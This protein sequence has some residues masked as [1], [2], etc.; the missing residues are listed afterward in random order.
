ML[1]C[2]R[3][4]TRGAGLSAVRRGL[5]L[6]PAQAP[7]TTA[8]ARVAASHSTSVCRDAAGN[9]GAAVTRIPLPRGTLRPACSKGHTSP[10]TRDAGHTSRMV[11]PGTLGYSRGAAPCRTQPGFPRGD[12]QPLPPARCVTRRGRIGKV[13]HATHLQGARHTPRGGRPVVACLRPRRGPFLPSRSLALSRSLS[14][15]LVPSRPL[16]LSLARR[17]RVEA[18]AQ[19]GC[20]Q[21]AAS[22][23][24]VVGGW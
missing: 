9:K 5:A 14:L 18:P 2:P 6:A 20:R 10:F 11:D 17:I 19:R 23:L 24:G 3:N 4:G 12:S 8:D 22:A 15:S 21:R 1:R 16:S 7:L 13:V